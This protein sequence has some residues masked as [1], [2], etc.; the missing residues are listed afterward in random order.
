MSTEPGRAYQAVVA[1]YYQV[2]QY[3]RR[4]SVTAAE[5]NCLNLPVKPY[6]E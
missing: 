5:I 6:R 4:I 3:R 1:S 2:L